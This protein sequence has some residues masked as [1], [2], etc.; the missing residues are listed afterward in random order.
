MGKRNLYFSQTIMSLIVL[1]NIAA[2]AG[3]WF[4]EA[5]LPN[6]QSEENNLWG[7][8]GSKPAKLL[9]LWLNFW[10][11]ERCFFGN[12]ISPWI[13][14]ICFLNLHWKMNETVLELILKL[15]FLF[16]STDSRTLN[17]Q[18]AWKELFRAGFI[19]QCPSSLLASFLLWSFASHWNSKI[20]WVGLLVSCCCCNNL[21][22]IRGLKEHKMTIL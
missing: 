1:E 6:E 19:W 21:L 12:V 10:V 5:E 16:L 18:K 17:I 2:M 15:E 7:H 9:W 20:W 14:R 4:L 8:L 11:F 22:Q 13:F 3:A